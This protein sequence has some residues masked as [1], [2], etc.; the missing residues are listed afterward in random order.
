EIEAASKQD[1][2]RVARLR[3]E[4][5]ERERMSTQQA[6]FS[7]L[8][9]ASHYL[10]GM[11]VRMHVKP[12]CEV[13]YGW[14]R[15]GI[16]TW[17]KTG[18]GLRS[19]SLFAGWVLGMTTSETWNQ[20]GERF[21]LSDK[22]SFLDTLNTD[23]VLTSVRIPLSPGGDGVIR[24]GH[25]YG[26]ATLVGETHDLA[27]KIRGAS[28]PNKALNPLIVDSPDYVHATSFTEVYSPSNTTPDTLQSKRF[29]AISW[30]IVELA[31]AHSVDL[32]GF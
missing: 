11:L 10:A 3:A 7:G 20:F 8:Q 14:T 31:T 12:T 22:V 28:P 9:N 6:R 1:A 18:M 32:T 27:G 19:E 17:E 4:N 21:V 16:K 23:G 29:N 30:G 2:A 26:D 15:W 13:R 25:I 24:W 5:A